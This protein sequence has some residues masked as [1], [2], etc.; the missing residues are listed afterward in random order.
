M[1]KQR[2]IS[3]KWD[4]PNVQSEELFNVPLGKTLK[5]KLDIEGRSS[6]AFYVVIA[7]PKSSW[8]RLSRTAGRVPFSTTLIVDTNGLESSQ[9]YKE[10]LQFRSHGEVVYTEPVYLTTQVYNAQ[11]LEAEPYALPLNP[12]RPHRNPFRSLLNGMLVIY[13][14]GLAVVY[15]VLGLL[16]I[17]IVLAILMIAFSS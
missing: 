3:I 1:L 12:G 2:D 8:L 6:E 13:H 5:L 9:G 7:Q 10:I 15:T 17:S 11:Q 4:R 16:I 14:L